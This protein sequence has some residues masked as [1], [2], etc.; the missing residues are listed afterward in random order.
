[1]NAKTKEIYETLAELQV[2]LKKDDEKNDLS[3]RMPWDDAVYGAYKELREDLDKA[4]MEIK[5]LRAELRKHR[6]LE[7]GTPAVPL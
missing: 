6:H 1:M 7:D 5:T 2:E 4:Q 3:A